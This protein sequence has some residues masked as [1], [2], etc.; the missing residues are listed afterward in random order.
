MGA[1][2]LTRCLIALL[3]FAL[4][5]LGSAQSFE[6]ERSLARAVS[7][8]DAAIVLYNI[9]RLREES[10]EHAGIYACLAVFAHEAVLA[11]SDND[12]RHPRWALTRKT[13]TL[14]VLP[15]A[16]TRCASF[17]VPGLE[18]EP[19]RAQ[20][21]EE[22]LP[23]F[24]RAALHVE[25]SHDASNE[26]GMVFREELERLQGLLGGPPEIWAKLEVLYRMLPPA[27]PTGPSTTFVPTVLSGGVSI[28]GAGYGALSALAVA[29]SNGTIHPS[30]STS[31]G[32]SVGLFLTLPGAWSWQNPAPSIFRLAGSLIGISALSG[33]LVVALGEG[34]QRS[35]GGGML[36][37]SGINLIWL[38]V[39]LMR[40]G[41]V[42]AAIRDRRRTSLSL[43]PWPMEGGG[44]L[45]GTG[46]F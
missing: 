27:I 20:H 36:I 17:S 5:G 16:Y 4:P 30:A 28:L 22:L 32:L 6:R 39:G 8:R 46:R 40:Q 15:D 31:L 11:R 10:G 42:R 12:L 23:Q 21:V 3:L 2:V 1:G 43:S 37:G 35:F 44:G 18:L 26:L 38:G 13:A 19:G 25:G 29:A 33:G 9:D 7:E 41:E 34:N 24:E 14:R 45:L